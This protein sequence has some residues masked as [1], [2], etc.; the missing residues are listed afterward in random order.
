MK[1]HRR[2]SAEQLKNVSVL[3]NSRLLTL[4]WK[5][6]A[7]SGNGLNNATQFSLSFG[8]EDIVVPAANR[9]GIDHTILRDGNGRWRD[10]TCP[11]NGVEAELGPES[12]DTVQDG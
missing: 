8:H 9:C 6:G 4:L 1:R 10:Q 12:A 3:K 5:L 11:R 7:L 2:T